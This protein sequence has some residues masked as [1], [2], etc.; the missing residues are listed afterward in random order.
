VIRFRKGSSEVEGWGE[1]LEAPKGGSKSGKTA[2]S[3]FCRE[4]L[5][6]SNKWRADREYVKSTGEKILS[7]GNTKKLLSKVQGARKK[8]KSARVAGGKQV[9]GGSYVQGG[10]AIVRFLDEPWRSRKTRRRA[11]IKKN[12]ETC[13]KRRFR[14]QAWEGER[15]RSLLIK[16]TFSKKKSRGCP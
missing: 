3:I 8:R 5:K 11:T 7:M 14:G 9:K 10:R 4:L 12:R 15:E 1:A 16:P 2:V 6:T 13:L